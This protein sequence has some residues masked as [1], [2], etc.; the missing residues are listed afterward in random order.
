MKINLPVFKD[1]DAK[2]VVTYQSWRWDLTMYW[3]VGCRD[4]TLLPYAIQSL[5]GYP[6]ELVWSSGTDITLDDVLTILDKH[7]NNVKALDALNQELFQLR[8]VDKETVLDW[9]I[10]LS[11]HL[12]V[13][14]ASFPDCFP[15]IK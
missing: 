11:R 1:E 15:L 5:Q 9:G 4:H 14:A 10:H 8:M 6:G 12:Q 13:L 7:Y 3:C 2:D